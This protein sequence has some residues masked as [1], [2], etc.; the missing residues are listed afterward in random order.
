MLVDVKDSCIIKHV[1]VCGPSSNNINEVCLLP[2]QHSVFLK[3]S[4]SRVYP[5]Q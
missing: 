4:L 5:E 3:H 1:F 2:L